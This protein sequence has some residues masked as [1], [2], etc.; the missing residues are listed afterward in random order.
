MPK[1][2]ADI[3]FIRTI[4]YVR[5]NNQG[6]W[7]IPHYPGNLIK[8]T[9]HFGTRVSLLEINEEIENP[10]TNKIQIQKNKVLMIRTNSGRIKLIFGYFTNLIKHIKTIPYC[11]WDSKNKW[12]TIPYSEQFEE[13][14]KKFCALNQLKISQEIEVPK[15]EGIP[16]LNPSQVIHYKSCPEAYINKLQELRY[17]QKI[18]YPFI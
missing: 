17:S 3:S 5:W 2:E 14:I 16:R 6:L 15:K 11:H 10:I 4:P 12:W 1:N 13:E 9:V 18:I 8:I 7:K